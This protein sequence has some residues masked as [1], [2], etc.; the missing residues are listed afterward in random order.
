MTAELTTAGTKVFGS[1]WA[2]LC[3]NTG[4]CVHVCVYDN[5]CVPVH[6]CV[7]SGAVHHECVCALDD[8]TLSAADRDI[9]IIGQCFSPMWMDKCC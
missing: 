9:D 1:G 3:Y 8:A 2:W 7:G 4:A 5:V 6:V